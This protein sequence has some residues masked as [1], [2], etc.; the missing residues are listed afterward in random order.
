MINITP[1]NS[2]LTFYYIY[3]NISVLGII[4]I[5]IYYL[6]EGW[7]TQ[8]ALA[9]VFRFAGYTTVMPLDGRTVGF[10]THASTLEL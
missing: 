2:S 4:S 1:K 10:N 3:L 7:P 6:N 5:T 9:Y 8:Y